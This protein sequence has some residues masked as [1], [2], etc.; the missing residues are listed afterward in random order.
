M[1]AYEQYVH[2]RPEKLKVSRASK[3]DHA[4]AYMKQYCTNLVSEISPSGE[5]DGALYIPYNSVSSF[6]T[7]YDYDN[8]A[9]GIKPELC[10]SS[11]SFRRAWLKIRKDTKDKVRLQDGKGTQPHVVIYLFA[12]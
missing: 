2:G 6:F 3:I 8:R 1:T 9:K 5:N 4:L 11:S 10:C 12:Y 7:Q